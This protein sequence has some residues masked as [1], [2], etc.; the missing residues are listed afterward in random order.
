M[1]IYDNKEVDSED[2]GEVQLL[3]NDLIR[4]SLKFATS[5]EQ[6]FLTH[7]LDVERALKFQRTFKFHVVG[8]KRI[9]EDIY[10]VPFTMTELALIKMKTSDGAEA[11]ELLE[12]ARHNYRG[13]PLETILHFRVHSILRQLRAKGHVIPTPSPKLTPLHSPDP[14]P[15][16]GG[17]IP[18]FPYLKE[19]PTMPSKRLLHPPADLGSCVSLP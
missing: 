14:S 16:R 3:T 8:E 1:T 12:P 17:D 5:R 9:K 19:S 15:N 13:Y 2:E 6:H 18:E 10:L 7:D 4:E 11:K